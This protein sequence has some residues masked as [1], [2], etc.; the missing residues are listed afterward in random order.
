[1]DIVYCDKNDNEIWT[2]HIKS[3]GHFGIV[4][5]WTITFDD[6][7]YFEL[8]AE[9]VKIIVAHENKEAEKIDADL[10]SLQNKITKPK[11][12]PKDNDIIEDG[13][14]SIWSAWCP[15]CGKK[16]M[17]VVRPGDAQCSHCG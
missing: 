15:M 5:D 9:L 17:H 4:R 7:S 2:N 1:M 8:P 6:D 3:A 13:F 11:H 14:G 16:S 10:V 12:K